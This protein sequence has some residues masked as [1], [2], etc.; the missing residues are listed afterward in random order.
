MELRDQLQATLG[1]TYTLER[2][3]GGGGMSRVFLA[4]E[5]ALDRRV[6]VKVL[7]PELGAG[8]NADRFDREILLAARLQHPHIVQV[9]S[10]GQTEGL[11]YYTM[12]FVDGESLRARLANEGAL[13][14]TDV[15]SILRDVARA[16]AYAHEHGVVHRDIKPENVLLSGGS[17]VVTDFGIAKALSD[18]RGHVTGATLTQFGTSLGTPAYMAPEQVAA[19]PA[20]DHRADLYAFGCVAYELLTGRAPFSGLAPQKLLVAQMTEMPRPVDELRPDTPPEL[21][22]LVMQ[23]LAKDAGSRPQ[24]A[25]DVVRELDQVTSTGTRAAMPSILLGGK[26]AMWKALGIYGGVFA[27]TALIAKAAIIA[28]GLP[29]WVLT[30]TVL[31]MALG[32]PVILFT[33]FVQ[34]ATRRALAATPRT[35]PA[36]TGA[37]QGTMTTIALK[38]SPH[39][40]WRRTMVA[41][42]WALGGFAV[43]VAA[44]MALRALGIGP[45]GSLLASGQMDAHQPLLVSEFA[46]SGGAD[47]ALGAVVAEGVR[48]DLEQS[49]AVHVMQA[50]AIQAALTRMQRPVMSR[51]DASLAREIAQREGL[52]A[53]VS[54]TITSLGTGFVVTAR[55]VAAESGNELASFQETADNPSELIPTVDKLSRALRGKIGES[56]RSVQA[57]PELD[58]VTTSSL[59][60]LKLYAAGMRAFNAGDYSKAMDLF[61]QSV[62]LDTTFA[63]AWRKLA[64]SYTNAGMS[65]V[66]VDEAITKAYEN[67]DHLSD[68]ERF[69]TI[70]TY[71]QNGPGHDR[72]KAIAAFEQAMASGDYGASAINL[73]SLYL[74]RRQFTA[75]DSALRASIAHDASASSMSYYALAQSLGD[76]GKFQEADSLLDAVDKRFGRRPTTV[77]SRALLLYDEGRVDS[78]AAFLRSAQAGASPLDRSQVLGLSAAVEMLHGRLGAYQSDVEEARA[79]Q[80][81][82]GVYAP[83]INDS[84]QSALFDVWLR[85]QPAVAVRKVDSALAATPLR[86]MPAAARP[87]AD[88]ATIYA[89]AGKPEQA[90]A[91]LAQYDADIHDT[92]LRR[93]LEPKRTYAMA[94]IAVAEKR[95]M[96]AVRGFYAS[97][98]LADGPVNDCV[99]CVDADIGMAFDRANMTDSAIA[100]YERYLKTPGAYRLLTDSQDLPLVYRRLG[101][102]YETKGNRSEA[103]T[104]YAKF[105]DLWKNADP[106]LQ[107]A[108]AEAKRRLADLQMSEKHS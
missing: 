77:Q 90:R 15:I 94:V 85:G 30:G 18:A 44:F 39:L 80:R 83:A 108:V 74:S 43:L 33:G 22:R 66:L 89:L 73:G 42:G 102:L 38:A 35:T 68:Q 72:G 36:A 61:K 75:A 1:S 56:L 2:E 55:I 100:H 82:I 95:P 9:L 34:R 47:T 20:V 54:G 37:V 81:S 60:A 105:V 69:T 97:D 96:D 19:D 64:V 4:L 58:A 32:L 10:A 29:Q 31:I 45:A 71:Y 78:A 3:L 86:T 17:A 51:V 98:S 46:V 107:P 13:P 21:A 53:I 40:T 93:A 92:T 70:G 59:P 25:A 88:A 41:G 63:M 84:M 49:R 48:A 79:I 52:K 26:H 62:A 101:E 16:L 14:I 7:P 106:D 24:R 27:V 11:P 99:A 67:R 5:T 6:V 87:Y 28:I 76:Q 12:P 50:N 8:V 57:S 91:M 104:Y 23:C 65:P 103:A